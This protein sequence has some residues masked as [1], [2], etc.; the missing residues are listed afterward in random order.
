[1]DIQPLVLRL[2]VLI[3]VL[4]GRSEG[5]GVWTVD[6]GSGETN[7]GARPGGNDLEVGFPARVSPD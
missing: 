7:S 5:V 1:M 2:E 3:H 4:V 6:A